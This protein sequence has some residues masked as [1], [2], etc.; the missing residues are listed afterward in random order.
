MKFFSLEECDVYTIQITFEGISDYETR[1][2]HA[3]KAILLPYKLIPALKAEFDSWKSND[4]FEKPIHKVYYILD[5]FILFPYY[6]VKAIF[7]G[8]VSK[9]RWKMSP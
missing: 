7:V 9:R 2:K 4:I 3:I 1:T 5:H 6:C 8:V